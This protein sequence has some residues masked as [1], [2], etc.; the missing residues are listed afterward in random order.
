VNLKDVKSDGG[1]ANKSTETWI[2]P[3]SNIGKNGGNAG[4]KLHTI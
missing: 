3:V 1:N 4:I 2:L